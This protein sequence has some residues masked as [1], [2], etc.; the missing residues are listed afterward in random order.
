MPVPVTNW[1][2]AT[3]DVF[4]IVS[5]VPTPPWVVVT[6]SVA[7][8]PPEPTAWVT[9]IPGSRKVPEG[10]VTVNEALAALAGIVRLFSTWVV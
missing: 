8:R 4:V 10:T 3:P 2:T 6:L 9:T 1:P 7:V 5:V